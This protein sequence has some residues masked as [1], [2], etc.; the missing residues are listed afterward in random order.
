MAL[1]TLMYTINILWLFYG[2]SKVENFKYNA[3]D[4]KTR[5]TIIIPFRNEEK[6]LPQLLNSISLLEYPDELFEVI[7]VDDASDFK[8]LISDLSNSEQALHFRFQISIINNIRKSNSPKKDAIN[9]AIA[10]AKN[11]WIITTDADCIVQKKWLKTFDAFI[12]KN[13]PKMIASAVTYTSD[14][15]FLE[16]FQKLDLISLQGITMGSFGNNQAFMCNGAN[17]CYQK[18]FF[19]SLNGFEGNEDIGSGDDV[20][21]LQKAI[22]K[23]KKGVHFLKSKETIV[24]THPENSWVNLFHQRVRWASKTGNYYSFYSKQL[25][26]SVFLMNLLL[27]IVFC[28]LVF[29]VIKKYYLF[30]FLFK[31]LID[32]I[33]I[34]RT[35]KFFATR[36]RYLFVGS[37]FYPFFVVSVAIYTIFGS[38]KWKGRSFKK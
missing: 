20:F 9:T 5:F 7:L 26:V 18:D 17:F 25:A 24:N 34:Y 19:Y 23:D 1:I 38:Y 32:F 22:K 29:G 2:F 14:I 37:L 10:V 35:S 21:L 6:N 12:Q 36:L 31:F 30:F 28:L 16:S 3:I 33:L 11:D 13:N 4:C 8:F 15:N 27:V